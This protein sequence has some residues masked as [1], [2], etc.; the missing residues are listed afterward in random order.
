MR[1]DLQKIGESLISTDNS[2]SGSRLTWWPIL[3]VVFSDYS[4]ISTFEGVSHDFSAL[5]T[6][7]GSRGAGATHTT[8]GAFLL[9]ALLFVEKVEIM[10]IK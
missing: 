4:K 3:G 1:T 7:I 8:S 10:I 5:R 2:G 9:V 6:F